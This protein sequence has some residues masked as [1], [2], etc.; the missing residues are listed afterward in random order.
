MK[1]ERVAQRILGRTWLGSVAAI[2]TRSTILVEGSLY[3][4][5]VLARL[6]LEAQPDC[7]RPQSLT[8]TRKRVYMGG[9]RVRTGALMVGRW[10]F[11]IRKEFRARFA[12]LCL[13]AR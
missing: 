6:R 8:D 10:A 2:S 12:S 13:S 11:R 9:G 5:P 4:A 7:G 3:E 1:Y